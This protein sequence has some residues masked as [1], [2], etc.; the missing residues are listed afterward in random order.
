M[1]LTLGV[2]TVGS[3]LK[4]SVYNGERYFNF[5]KKILNQEELFFDKLGELAGKAGGGF[6]DFGKICVINGPGRFTGMRISYTFARIYEALSGAE[7]YGASVFDALAFNLY[8]K[9][10]IGGRFRNA[11]VSVV[12]RAFKDEFYLCRYEIKKN[13][14]RR[15]SEPLWLK[16]G[17]A[18]EKLRSFSGT[19]VG[20]SEEYGGIYGLSPS[21][22]KAGASVSLIKPENII[23]SALY[24]KKRDIKPLYL[25]P[26]KYE[27]RDKKSS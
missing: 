17:E 14:L 12:C 25:K 27:D 21:A 16:A 18:A 24:F 19:V 22:E 23:K 2:C 10:S 3:F 8:E 7:L 5:S 20:D 15:V 26:A 13:T 6:G 4:L 9:L 1:K 11:G